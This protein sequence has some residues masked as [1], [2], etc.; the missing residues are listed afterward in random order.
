MTAREQ[1]CAALYTGPL[2]TADVIVLLTGDGEQRVATAVELMRQGGAQRIVIT[3]GL[4]EP[5]YAV[6]ATRLMGK[7]MAHGVAPSAIDV[8]VAA[9]NTW[10]QAQ[11]V[12]ARAEAN[13]W[14]RILLVASNYHAPRA[15]L[16]FVRALRLAGLDDTVQVLVVPATASWFQAPEGVDK[17]RMELLA[18]EFRKV[19][20]YTNHVATWDEGLEYLARWEGR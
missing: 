2:L 4:D 10:E 19:A 8:D 12:V 9:M 11:N 5:P 7:V 20:E 3:G 16:T 14:K 18:D 13:G 6:P 15:F 1:C 17:T